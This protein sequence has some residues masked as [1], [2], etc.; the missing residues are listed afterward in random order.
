MWRVLIAISVLL[1]GTFP[2]L[3]G[4]QIVLRDGRTLKGVDVRREREGGATYVLILESGAAL[5]IPVELVGQVLTGA[6]IYSPDGFR[7]PQAET[8][9]GQP[10]SEELSI[11][12]GLQAFGAITADMLLEHAVEVATTEPEGAHGRATRVAD[13]HPGPLADP[14]RRHQRRRPELRRGALHHAR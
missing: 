4:A 14:R 10:I 13:L 11:P 8:I 12:I 6:N 3:A 9:G 7:Y 1:A 2:A 5:A